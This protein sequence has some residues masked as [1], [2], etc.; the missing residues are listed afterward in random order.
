MWMNALAHKQQK[1]RIYAAGVRCMRRE[2]VRNPV[3][4]QELNICNILDKIIEYQMNLICHRKKRVED[5]LKGFT[6]MR[7]KADCTL[8]GRISSDMNVRIAVV[9][10]D[11]CR[12]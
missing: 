3:T 8:N 11:P 6:S 7:G 10:T 9:F 12:C 2:H 1:T 4:G 5:L